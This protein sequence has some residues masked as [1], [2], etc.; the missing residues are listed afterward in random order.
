MTIV[1][2]ALLGAVVG[3]LFGSGYFGGVWAGVA[4]GALAG[5]VARLGARLERLERLERRLERQVVAVGASRA[6]HSAA[7]DEDRASLPAAGP[8]RPPRES[9]EPMRTPSTAPAARATAAASQ[10]PR[11]PPNAPP[12]RP[13]LGAAPTTA[14]ATAAKRE[15][16]TPTPSAADAWLEH[17]KLWFTTGNVPA[18][19]GVVLSVFGTGFLI[20]EGI[21]RHWL[22][23]PLPMRLALVALFGMAL[24]VVGWRLRRTRRNYALSVQGGGIAVLY[25][26]T[27]AAYAVYHLLPP[28]PAFGL[29]VIVTAAAGALAVAQDARS[30]AV[31]GIVGGFMAPLL[32]ATDAGNHVALFGYYAVL[33]L[34]I[35]AI[36]WFKAWRELNVLGFLFTFCIGSL[37][38]Y[39]AYRPAYFASTEPFLALFVVLYTVIPTLFAT[40]GPPPLRGFVDGTLVFGTPL[41]GFA[42]QSQLVGD[43]EYGLAYSAVVLAAWYGGLAAWVWRRAQPQLEVLMESLAALA[44]VFLTVAVPLALDARWTSIA[45]ALQG[46]ALVWLGFRQRRKLALL[47]GVFLQVISGA[48]YWL[49]AVVGLPTRGVPVLN[50]YFLGAALIAAAGALSSWVFEPERDAQRRDRAWYEPVAVLLLTW[51]AAWWFWAGLEEVHRWAAALEL[52]ADLSFAAATTWAAI[53]A[54]GRLRW[55]RLNAVGLALWPAALVGLLGTLMAEA[56]PLADYGWIAWPLV[57]AAA[58][59]FLR[60]RES[61]Y[62]ELHPALHLIAS[63][64]LVALLARETHWQVAEWASAAWPPAATLAVVVGCVALTLRARERLVWP[65]TRHRELYVGLCCGGVLLGALLGAL[66]LNLR[67]PGDAWPL[68]YVPLLNPL[69]L[70]SLFMLL[71]LVRWSALAQTQGGAGTVM[72][73]PK[74][75]GCGLALLGWFLLTTAVARAVHHWAG[76]PFR[77]DLLAASTTFQAS[78]SIVWSTAALTA[79]VIGARVGRRGTWLAG[80]A[81]M[82]VVVV[83]LFIVELGDAGTLGRVVSFLGVGLL[84]LVVGYLAPVPPRGDPADGAHEQGGEAA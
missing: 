28:G 68:P 83:K 55:L 56:H 9:V 78:L 22:V 42:L 6:G 41:V 19:V 30:L 14:T 2:F 35:L 46:A 79:M 39:Q 52:A 54:A 77:L 11:S 5:W 64:I 33:N 8:P 10:A 70:A 1:V 50:G 17:V 13:P 60:T 59:T 7:R 69:E 84:L 53:F 3:A 31:L 24:L 65:L 63:W 25:L 72:L 4:I 40:R 62:P 80:A 26:T 48:A 16:A 76:V 66:V 34:T 73:D 38:G 32:T 20:K 18:K 23:L 29:L 21:D 57:F 36:A 51:A 43:T 58:L 15:L 71:V 82:G 37:W 44:V 47:T 61:Q 74:L 75:R 27:Y 12:T 45:W 81:L 49:D 67:S